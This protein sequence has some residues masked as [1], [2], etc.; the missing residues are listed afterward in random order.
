MTRAVI[1]ASKL[2]FVLL[3]SVEVVSVRALP[4][5]SRVSCLGEGGGGGGAVVGG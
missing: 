2:V 3:L 5:R 4:Y 1:L